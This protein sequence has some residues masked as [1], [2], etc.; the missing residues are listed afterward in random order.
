MATLQEM[1]V[2]YAVKIDESG[3]SRLHTLLD[4]NRKKAS[5]T[6]AAFAA[7]ES[8]VGK[9]GKVL[10]QF[11]RRFPQLNIAGLSSRLQGESRAGGVVSGIGIG[12]IGDGGNR[13][14]DAFRQ[15]G[16][17]A[18]KLPGALTGICA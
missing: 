9:L 8:A 13:G 18:R 3:V 4:Q 14:P 11:S 12:P 10:E 7:L 16:R 15:D 6:A 2:S 5:E 17:K 1:L